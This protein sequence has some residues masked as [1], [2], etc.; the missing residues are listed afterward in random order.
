MSSYNGAVSDDKFLKNNLIFVIM[1][2]C[3]SDKISLI[4]FIVTWYVQ[5]IEQ[6]KVKWTKLFA[7]AQILST[8]YTL[9]RQLKQPQWLPTQQSKNMIFQ[10][11][12]QDTNKFW[13]ESKKRGKL[14][15]RGSENNYFSI[16]VLH[17][18]KQYCTER[19]T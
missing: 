9:S 8:P 7:V 4:T 18:D 13:L 5:T 6:A 1:E 16:Y 10:Y 2:S 12:F 3:Y 14:G 19:N 17:Y 11:L 15:S